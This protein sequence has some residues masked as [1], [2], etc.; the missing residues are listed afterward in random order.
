MGNLIPNSVFGDNSG[1]GSGGGSVDSVTAGDGTI[2]IGGTA[3][4]PTV[5]VATAGVALA[6]MAN[7]AQDQF[8]G[9]TTA[10]TGVPETATITAAARTVLD[11]TTVANMVNTLGGATSTGTGGLVRITDAILVTPNLGTPSAVVL[12]NATG[13]AASLTAGVASAVAVGGI[14]GLGTGVG[15]FLATPSSA[16]LA[17]AVTDETGSGALVFGTSPTITTPTISGAAQL[18]ENAS[19]R[20]D[21]ALS[22]DGTWSGTTI[23]GTAGATLAFGEVCY[24]AAADSRWELTDADAASTSGDVLVGLCVLAAAADGDPTVMLLSGNIRA[25]TAF[26]ALTIGA[27]VYISTTPGAIQVAK[28]SGTDDVIRRVGFA[29]TADSIVVSISPDYI[30]AV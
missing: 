11:D 3:A 23:A 26:P 19:I 1:G 10:S 12:T 25:D 29:L 9:R 13:T 21:A 18:A 14:T 5:R 8:I 22:A 4:D 2:T 6:N 27:P 16:N 28:P 15:T 30:T 7:L 17:A 20:L 24:L